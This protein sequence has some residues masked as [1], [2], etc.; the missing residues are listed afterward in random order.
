MGKKY[1]KLGVSDGKYRKWE[2]WNATPV[3]LETM[4]NILFTV[5]V[6]NRQKKSALP[7]QNP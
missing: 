6:F 2:Y 7:L 5:N 4:F 1:K 3:L